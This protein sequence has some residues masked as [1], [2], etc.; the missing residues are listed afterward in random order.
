MRD[1][2]Q[3]VVHASATPPFM[4]IGASEIRVWHKGR[5][6]RDIGYHA[7]IKRNGKV[8]DGRPI[9]EIGAH[10]KGHNNESFGICLVGGV[11]KD[12]KSEFNFTRHQMDS[13]IRLLDVLK[14]EFPDAEVLGHRDF[15]GVAKACPCFAVKEWYV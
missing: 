3:L 2:K 13:L 12:N 10:V 7:V 9:A 5:G 1:I 8:E 6:W 4:E 15:P 14:N 11:D